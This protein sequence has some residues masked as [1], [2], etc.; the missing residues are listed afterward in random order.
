MSFSPRRTAPP[1]Q[2]ASCLNDGL[3]PPLLHEG[4]DSGSREVALELLVKAE[5]VPEIAEEA[6]KLRAAFEIEK[7][8]DELEEL[9]ELAQMAAAIELK[10]QPEYCP[11]ERLA[12]ARAKM[13]LTLRIG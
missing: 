5:A 4:L 2:P 3:L 9:E 13:D 1:L 8:L 11:E 7:K 12:L 10:Q 6:S